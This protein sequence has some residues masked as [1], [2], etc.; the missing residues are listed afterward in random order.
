MPPHMCWGVVMI[1]CNPLFALFFYIS[2]SGIFRSIFLEV[3]KNEGLLEHFRG[4][5]QV[6]GNSGN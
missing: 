5:S 6:Q 1:T 4:T 2:G 3:L